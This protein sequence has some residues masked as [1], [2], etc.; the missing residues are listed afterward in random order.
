MSERGDSF[1]VRSTEFVVASDIESQ[2]VKEGQNMSF[3]ADLT[4]KEVANDFMKKE[5]TIKS[6]ST[7]SGSPLEGTLN[8]T[9]IQTRDHEAEFGQSVKDVHGKRLFDL[10]TNQKS[11][12]SNINDDLE[13][14]RTGLTANDSYQTK[15]H[16]VTSA[17]KLEQVCDMIVSAKD[18]K[19]LGKVHAESTQ[20]QGGL[21]ENYN[22]RVTD[23]AD[24]YLGSVSIF[25]A[26]SEDGKTSHM[27]ASVTHVDTPIKH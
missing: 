18:G 27:A 6:A 10:L 5:T 17:D 16:C 3:R 11:D 1:M 23:A 19:V 21:L 20:L 7:I 26:R 24:K 22:S 13:I 15:G 12:A 9:G 14:T 2:L 8:I 25:S 4:V